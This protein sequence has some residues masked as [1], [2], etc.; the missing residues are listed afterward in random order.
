MAQINPRYTEYADALIERF[1][2]CG[3]SLTEHSRKLTR[4]TIVRWLEE[5][6][7]FHEAR[8]R[9]S[10]TPASATV[11]D[12]AAET[13][14]NVLKSPRQSPLRWIVQWIF[15]IGFKLLGLFAL[16][17]LPLHFDEEPTVDVKK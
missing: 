6:P 15:A 11:S 17:T 2:E 14:R 12:L 1:E 4:E 5:L 7:L 9:V 3:V 10:R 8:K 16:W 13:P